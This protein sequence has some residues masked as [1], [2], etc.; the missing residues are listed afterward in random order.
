[1]ID[2]TQFNFIE[3]KKYARTMKFLADGT[4]VSS[5][6]W[7]YLLEF[8]DR[9]EWDFMMKEFQKIRLSDLPIDEYLKLWLYATSV[10]ADIIKNT[11]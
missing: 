9:N 3:I 4:E 2:Q 5:R 6:T 11:I 8:N 1:M 7:Y 10:D